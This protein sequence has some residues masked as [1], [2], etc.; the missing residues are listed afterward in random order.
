MKNPK[1]AVFS[2]LLP[3]CIPITLFVFIKKIGLPD[4]PWRVFA[5]WQNKSSLIFLIYP[6]E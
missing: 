3:L 1:L 5:V 6:L 4:E 2:S